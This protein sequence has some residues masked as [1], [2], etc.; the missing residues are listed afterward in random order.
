MNQDNQDNQEDIYSKDY[1]I[2]ASQTGVSDML[3]IEKTFMECNNDTSNTI[4]K[5]MDMLPPKGEPKEPT[6]IEMF[7]TIL[8]EKERIYHDVM[9]G[10]KQ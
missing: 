1:E 8:D 9:S 5:L 7:R 4:L 10:K 6:K 3:V 2:I